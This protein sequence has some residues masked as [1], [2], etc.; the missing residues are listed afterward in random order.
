MASDLHIVDI[1]DGR[2]NKTGPGELDAMFKA[3]TA[4]TT[5]NHL[6]VHFH[7]GLVSGRSAGET[8][9]TL[10]PVYASGDAYPCFFV[11]H[12]DIWNTIR[13]NLSELPKDRAFQRLVKRVLQLV[14][15]KLAESASTRGAYLELDSLV[16]MPSTLDELEAW[17]AARDLPQP[18]KRSSKR[19]TVTD[20][21]D[22]Q[23][24][25]IQNELLADPELKAEAKRVAAQLAPP[26]EPG[27][28]GGQAAPEDLGPPSQLSRDVLDE[29]STELHAQSSDVAEGETARSATLVLY[30]L[31][32]H[33]VKVVI[34]VVGRYTKKRDHGLYTTVVEEVIRDLFIDSVGAVVWSLMKKDTADAFG[35]ELDQF[36]GTAFVDRLAKWWVSAAQRVT[37]VGHSTGALFITHLLERADKVLPPDRQF[38][39]V[40]LAPACSF[41]FMA[42]HLSVFRRRVKGIRVF[43]LSD[44]L[45]RGYWEIPAVYRGSLLYLVS[46]LLEDS[47]VDMPLVGMQRY[48]SGLDPF[49]DA[50]IVDVT[51]YLDQRVVWSVAK[52]PIGHRTAAARHGAFTED[53]A[54]QESLVEI[55]K[56]GC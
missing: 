54:T 26:P 50:A 14:A 5:T 49:K 32:K 40:F 3:V 27:T 46:G 19:K 42:K 12:S 9:E 30:T 6:V 20:L 10:L 43:A 33:A 52:N 39:V 11:W 16:E 21:S 7:G 13:K 48:Y 2:F 24:K 56:S 36:G 44:Q 35:E 1:S 23:L 31:A 53:E 8:I 4:S 22:T 29:I 47:M 25:Q 45:E 15:G 28:R 41:E 55:L 18:K 51:T 37:L 17:A 38:D 34:A